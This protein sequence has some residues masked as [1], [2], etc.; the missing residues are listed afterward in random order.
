VRAGDQP[1]LE[2]RD[3]ELLPLVAQL[4][5]DERVRDIIVHTQRREI[6]AY[7]AA[8]DAGCGGEP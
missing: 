5:A 4:L 8:A 7:V 6:R 3:R 2:L 1:F